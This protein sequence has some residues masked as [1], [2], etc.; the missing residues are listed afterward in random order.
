MA[1]STEITW[2]IN[3]VDRDLSDGFIYQSHWTMTGVAKSDG[4]G[5]ATVTYSGP[6]VGFGTVRPSPM[7]AYNDVTQANV[8]TWTQTAIGS[9]DIAACTKQIS[10]R[11]SRMIN[12]PTPT[13]GE[14]VPW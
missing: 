4:V 5:I 3:S 9:T 14:G 1:I 6:P 7:I 10:E 8:I 2:S 13:T 12:P 11:M